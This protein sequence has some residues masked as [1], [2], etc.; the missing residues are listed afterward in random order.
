MDKAI[1]LLIAGLRIALYSN[2]IELSES[3]SRK[4]G[5]FSTSD[6]AQFGVNIS[7]K[8]TE[9]PILFATPEIS[10]SG[11]TIHLSSQGYAGY[12]DIGQKTGELFIEVANPL[13]AVEYYLRILFATLT[14]ENEGIMV[15]GAGIMHKGGGYVFFGHSGSGKT[16]ISRASVQDIVLNDDLVVL[17]MHE[18]T[19]MIYSTPFSNPTQVAPQKQAVNLTAIFNLVQGTTVSITPMKSAQALAELISN[20]PVI[21]SNPRYSLDLLDRCNSILYLIPAYQLHFLP[22][23]SFWQ[24][25]DQIFNEKT[26]ESGCNYEPD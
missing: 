7:W 1:A 25:I 20:I 24:V 18:G 15:H 9:R 2:N 17:K 3:L 11:I 22:D 4:Y 6:D 16:T 26:D 21:S 12:F 10:F 19:W 5:S 13:D 14:F 8:K 23:D